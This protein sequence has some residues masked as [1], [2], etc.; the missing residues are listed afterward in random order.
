MGALHAETCVRSEL[1][2][3]RFTSVGTSRRRQLRIVEPGSAEHIDERTDS[4][5]RIDDTSCHGD[6]FIDASAF[7]GDSFVC[8]FFGNDYHR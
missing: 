7:H 1:P 8:P 3:T 4:D 5:H 6:G 2:I